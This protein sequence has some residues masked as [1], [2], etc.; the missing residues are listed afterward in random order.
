MATGNPIWMDRVY[1]HISGCFNK[2]QTALSLIG[3]G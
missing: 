1:A 3:S 2:F